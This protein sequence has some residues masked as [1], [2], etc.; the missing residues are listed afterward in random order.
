MNYKDKAEQ[1]KKG[2]QMETW[3]NQPITS[4][5][6]V[7]NAKNETLQASAWL[8]LILFGVIL[9]IVLAIWVPT[10]NTRFACVIFA[11]LAILQSFIVHEKIKDLAEL[12]TD[13]AQKY[14]RASVMKSHV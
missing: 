14:E 4:L 2:I 10:I 11:V 6:R 7:K 9:M 3:K 5:Q 1:S 13:S 12:A 8:I